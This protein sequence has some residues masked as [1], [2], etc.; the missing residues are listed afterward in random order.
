[1]PMRNAFWAAGVGVVVAVLAFS[2]RGASKQ[3]APKSAAVQRGEYLVTVG[4]CNDCHTPWK[5][6]P[7]GP[8]P[9]RTRLLSGHPEGLQMPAAPRLEPPWG[10]TVSATF[11]AWSG[12]WGTSFTANLTP[13]AETGLGKW[14]EQNFIE[15]LRT[16]RHL[17]RGRPILPPMPWPNYAQMTDDDLKAMFTYLRTIPPI[18]NRVP[19]PILAAEGSAGAAPAGAPSQTGTGSSPGGTGQARPPGQ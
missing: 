6:G 19:A 5:M 15:S 7:N 12:P 1:M 16:G 13:D 8:E 14:S 2:A 11:T 3:G 9:D 4:G 17:G 18:R 10:A